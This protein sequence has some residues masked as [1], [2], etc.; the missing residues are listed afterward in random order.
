MRLG[1]AAGI[2]QAGEDV[3]ADELRIASEHIFNRISRTQEA[4]DRVHGVMRVPLITGLPL[5]TS[6]FNSIRCITQS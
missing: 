6:G 4:E 1:E 2:I 5:Q 3:G